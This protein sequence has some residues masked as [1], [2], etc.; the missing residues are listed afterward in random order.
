VKLV[1]YILC[2]GYLNVSYIY[3]FMFKTAGRSNFIQK[4]LVVRIVILM[5]ILK[6]VLQ[7][8]MRGCGLYSAVP[9][10]GLSVRNVLPVP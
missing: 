3:D 7:D 5:I 2:Q 1:I 6:W 10:Y 9:V 8:R 4:I